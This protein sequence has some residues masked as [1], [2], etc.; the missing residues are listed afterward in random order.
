MARGGVLRCWVTR[1]HLHGQAVT[2]S[3]VNVG[4][5]RAPADA[6]D[7]SAAGGACGGVGKPRYVKGLAS[8]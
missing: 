7:C 3:H 5:A 4:V 6:G 1:T 2:L 8:P